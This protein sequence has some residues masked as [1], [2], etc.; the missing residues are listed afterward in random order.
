MAND[1]KNGV[2]Y[3]TK[4]VASLTV[5]FPEDKVMCSHC[6]F[7]YSEGDLKRFRCRITHD[8]IYNPF[9]PGLPETC[10]FDLTGEVTGTP[11][12]KES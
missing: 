1:F 9:Y 2:A 3:F 4:A 6:D 12:R 8:E 5:H 7:C 10:P 11:P